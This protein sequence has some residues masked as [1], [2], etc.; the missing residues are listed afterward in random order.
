MT[1]EQKKE[2]TDTIIARGPLVAARKHRQ[3]FDTTVDEALVAI[4]ELCKGIADNVDPK[5]FPKVCCF[6][7]MGTCGKKPKLIKDNGKKL[8]NIVSSGPLGADCGQFLDAATVKKRGK[9]KYLTFSSS[10]EGCTVIYEQFSVFVWKENKAKGKFTTFKRKAHLTKALPKIIEGICKSGEVSIAIQ[11]L[12]V[13]VKPEDEETLEGYLQRKI[14]ASR[15]QR[16]LLMEEVSGLDLKGI[17]SRLTTMFNQRG[18]GDVLKTQGFESFM[19][20]FFPGKPWEAVLDELIIS[21]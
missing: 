16:E 3:L 18:L 11:E 13:T 12:G 5:T 15:K 8:F 10:T 19:S 7:C 1:E 6:N 21:S 2:I 9:E 20:S 14:E 17:E 4:D